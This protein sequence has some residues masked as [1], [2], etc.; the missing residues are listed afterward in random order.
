M[1]ESGKVLPTDAN[2][3]PVFF[4]QEI[5]FADSTT[6]A[7]ANMAAHFQT[8]RRSVNGAAFSPMPTFQRHASFNKLQK[9]TSMGRRS[10]DTLS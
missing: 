1:S 6:G 2:S 4:L 8:R 3:M 5:K 7:V 9:K 10:S